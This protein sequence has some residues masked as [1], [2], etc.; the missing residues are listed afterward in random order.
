MGLRTAAEVRVVVDGEDEGRGV[1]GEP[2]GRVDGLCADPGGE[3][4]RVVVLAREHLPDGDA[5][6]MEGQGEVCGDVAR[7]D[8]GDV[9]NTRLL[10]RK[11]PLW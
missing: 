2:L 8:E 11:S 7:A 3:E 9:F 6:G 10:Q 5:D 4:G 1:D